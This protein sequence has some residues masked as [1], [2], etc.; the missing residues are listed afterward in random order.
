M[1]EGLPIQGC[2]V[3]AVLCNKCKALTEGMFNTVSQLYVFQ[4]LLHR[5]D[6]KG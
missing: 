5:F 1:N 4:V 3:L 2:R 6:Q